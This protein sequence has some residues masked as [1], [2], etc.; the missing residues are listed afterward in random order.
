MNEIDLCFTPATEL[1]IHAKYNYHLNE[2]GVA[3]AYG[4]TPA[5][6]S[7][8]VYA[9]KALEFIDGLEVTAVG[10]QSST[11]SLTIKDFVPSRAEEVLTELIKLYN[12]QS[13][14]EKN[15]VFENSLNLL[16]ELFA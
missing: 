3:V 1:E 13:I 9:R 2:D 6:Y 14:D 15:K 5:D 12:Q 4:R 8:D 10:E 16:N 7:T 11:L